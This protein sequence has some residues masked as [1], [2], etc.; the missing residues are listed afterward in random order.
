MLFPYTEKQKQEFVKRF[1]REI[2][3]NGEKSLGILEI[4]ISNDNGQISETIY[5]T[6]DKN[7]VKQQDEIQFNDNI[8]E[9]AYI[10]DDTSGLV[11]CYLSLIG[12]DNGR[13]GKYV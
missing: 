1:G 5:I 6:D 8:Y 13:D 3:I 12:D 4:N 7:K 2:L 10:V 11:D 9:I